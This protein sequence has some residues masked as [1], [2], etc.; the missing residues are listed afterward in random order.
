M[1][2]QYKALSTPPA[3]ALKIIKAGNLKGKTDINPQ[4][5]LEALTEQFGLCGFGWKYEI[6]DKQIIDCADGQKLI[7][8]QILLYVK[9][10]EEWSAPIIGLGGDFII[11]KNKN[12]LVPNDEAYKMC[13]TD[14]LGNA[15]KCLGVAADIYRGL[16]DSKYEHRS[17]AVDE[18]PSKPI[19]NVTSTHNNGNVRYING[20]QCQVKSSNGNYYAVEQ[21]PTKQLEELAGKT[22]YSAA[23]G[24]IQAVLNSRKV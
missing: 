3:S 6:T 4:W 14:A 20:N 9:R 16:A 11:E 13:L 18:R 15:A 21:L 2:E 23:L 8:M 22:E 24:A 12:G 5:R 7:F 1:D 19:E 10:G 17:V